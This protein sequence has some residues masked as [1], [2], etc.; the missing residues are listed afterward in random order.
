MF[1][2]RPLLTVLVLLSLSAVS[3]SAAD[4]L[5]A[6]AVS[7]PASP[8]KSI[9]AEGGPAS[10]KLVMVATLPPWWT[11][12]CDELIKP[13]KGKS[14]YTARVSAVKPKKKD[15]KGNC[16]V[17]DVSLDVELGVVALGSYWLNLE[18]RDDDGEYSLRAVYR[19]QGGARCGNNHKDGPACEW[20][21]ITQ[22]GAN[23]VPTR[24]KGGIE[25]EA[26]KGKSPKF[27]AKVTVETPNPAYWVKL[28]K[29]KVEDG[30]I[31]IDL[32]Q[33][34]KNIKV[35]QATSTASADVK[36]GKL[37]TGTWRIEIRVDD[38]LIS[39]YVAKAVIAD[40]ERN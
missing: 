30:V 7:F 29:V 38:K 12:K 3:L 25:I 4:S 23:P 20:I 6:N 19:L 40:A 28:K 31:K 10:M 34:K 18:W 37:K 16:L 35:N 33:G 2:L 13:A 36:F 8:L 22:P 24:R 15:K 32:K 39:V 11:L 21:T 9:K 26:G 1:S 14:T 5:W 17:I 27:K